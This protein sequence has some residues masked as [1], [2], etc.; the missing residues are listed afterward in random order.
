MDKVDSWELYDNSLGLALLIADNNKEYDSTMYEI[1]REN[2]PQNR[3]SSIRI[4]SFVN[5]MG[6]RK[7]SETV[8]REKMQRGESVV[9][10]VEGRIVEFSPE[11]VLWL[12]GSFQRDLKDWEIDY[13]RDLVEEGEDV[14]YGNGLIFPASMVLKLYG[15]QI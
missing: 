5:L 4:D 3:V 9:Y 14:D 6:I 8:L 15:K 13:L 11:D 10:S 12:Y 2:N 7:F 1:I